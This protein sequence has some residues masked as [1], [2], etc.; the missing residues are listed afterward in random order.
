M[1]LSLYYGDLSRA[2]SNTNKLAAELDDY[3][4]SLSRRVQSK[5]YSVEGGMSSALNTADYYIN[6]KIRDLRIKSSN[7]RNLSQ[8][9]NELLNTA[10]RVDSDV[11]TTIE[12]NQKNLFSKH[13]EL[14]P[15]NAQL[16]LT[17]FL[18]DMKKVPILGTLIRSGEEIGKGI[19]DLKNEIRYWYKCEGGK[20]FVGILLSVA[21]LVLAIVVVVASFVIS[22]GVLAIIAGIA[23]LI[24]AVIGYFNS[25]TNVITSVQAY[26]AA[27]GGH[28]GQAKIYARQDKVSDVLRDINFHDKG[29]NRGTNIA[30]TTLDVTEAVCGVLS[31][32]NGINETRKDLKGFS[33]KKTFR[34]ICQPR[35]ADGTFATGKPS[36]WNG[37]K[38]ITS[39]INGKDMIL[40]D[41]N[42]KNLSRLSEFNLDNKIK[43]IGKLS[44]AI[45]G[46]VGDFDSI[47]EGEMTF[48]EF[49]LKR[50]AKGLDKSIL[51]TETLQVKENKKDGTLYSAY[52]K[53]KFATIVKG[54][55][56]P[57]DDIGIGKIL[58]GLEPSGELKTILAPS[59]GLIGKIQ[60]IKTAVTGWLPPKITLDTSSKAAGVT[61]WDSLQGYSNVEIVKPIVPVVNICPV[62]N[63][64]TYVLPKMQ[65]NINTAFRYPYF[66]MSAAV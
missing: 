48:S 22:G 43:T 56:I 29:W 46:I 32:V 57:I 58:I 53:T 52:D 63:Q 23:G 15:S 4:D 27:V 33:I 31:I 25:I 34:A 10:K 24:S 21:E 3:C 14:R 8:K 2:I 54:I 7:A 5:M 44:D 66:N 36:L 40:G 38:S 35:N 64:N 47:N 13:A 16:Y 11:K 61:N 9:I 59:S 18:S 45:N 19:N 20:E 28:P 26:Q 17:S 65:F 30:A 62:V 60:N 37:L 39:R 55:R 12:S 42:V 51:R 41:L 50:L 6:S 49:M 1:R